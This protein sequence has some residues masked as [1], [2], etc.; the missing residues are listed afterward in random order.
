VPR[1]PRPLLFGAATV[2][3]VGVYAASVFLTPTRN[4]DT[5]LDDSTIRDTAKTACLRLDAG[6]A[7]QP[8]LPESASVAERQAQ[9][10]AQSALIAA[11]VQRVEQLP[12]KTLD[13]DP[14]ARA[15]LSD[16]RAL[17]KARDDYAAGGLVGEFTVPLEQGSPITRRMSDVD[18]DACTVPRALLTAP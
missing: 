15:W 17:A 11:L 10:A 18:I 1:L 3:V 7:G 6:L 9:I 13:D 12:A 4:K 2:V 16:W 8:R 14:P 5:R